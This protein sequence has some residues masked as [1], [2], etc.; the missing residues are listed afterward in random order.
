MMQNITEVQRLSLQKPFA[1]KVMVGDEIHDGMGTPIDRN[2]GDEAR[3]V[4]VERS[5]AT[6]ANSPAGPSPANKDPAQAKRWRRRLLIGALAAVFLAIAAVLGVPW[7]E[8]ALN[9]VST[10]DAYVNGHVTFVSARVPGQVSK[11]LVDDN[12]RVHK[13][14]LLAELDKE[15]YQVIVAIKK[16][17]VDIAKADLASAEASVRGIEAKA[18]SQRWKLQHAIED[19]DNQIKLLQAKIAALDKSKASLKLAEVEF[20]RVSKLVA[21]GLAASRE[22]FDQREAALSVARADV[23]QALADIHQIRVSLGL[24]VTPARGEDLGQVPPDLDETFSSVREAQA[25]LIDTA[26]ELGVSHTYNQT[27]KQMVEEFEK[28]NSGDV[29]VTLARLVPN[30]PA[31]KQAR[32]KLESAERDL[33]QAELNLR[34]CRIVADID[35]VIARRNVNPGN[36]VLAGQSLMAIRSVKEIWV[37]AN[38]KETQLGDLRIGQ[39]ADLYVDMYGGRHVFRGRITG[40]TMGTGSTLALLPPQNA[41]GNFVKVVQRLPVRIE[42]QDYDPDKDPLFIGLSIVPYVYINK[43][44]TGPDAG[45]VLQAS[46]PESPSDLLAAPP[47][48]RNK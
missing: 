6:Q 12:N 23:T 14:D 27:P 11:V 42:L 39:A 38:F 8:E 28:R 15:P 4:L 7:V 19:V 33:D 9:T 24:P 17:A 10:D 48:A 40:F 32:A 41:T 45:K 18:W 16:A 21:T 46:L 26:A 13:G 31:V 37:D 22:Q 47:M 29:D 2:S 36:D 3:A 1:G 35:G 34:Y 25:E 44:A 30:A 20:E 43:P 5:A